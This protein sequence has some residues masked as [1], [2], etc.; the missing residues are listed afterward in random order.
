LTGKQWSVVSG[1]W[2]V[3]AKAKANTEI[4]AFT[5]A[6]KLAGDPGLR[7]ND[8]RKEQKQ[9]PPPSTSLRVRNGKQSET[10]NDEMRGALHFPFDS[11]RSLRVRSG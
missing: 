2:S 10:S 6:S 5:P 4:L 3:R 8:E 1:Q 7:Q 11:L 9:I